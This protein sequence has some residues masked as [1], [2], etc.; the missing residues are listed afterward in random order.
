MAELEDKDAELEALR[1]EITKLKLELADS[2][3]KSLPLET[4][5]SEHSTAE[6]TTSTTTR[7][8]ASSD[9]SVDVR[10]GF[11]FGDKTPPQ[12]VKMRNVSLT[13]ESR[14][15]EQ[16]TPRSLVTGTYVFQ[17]PIRNAQYKRSAF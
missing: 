1:A 12:V 17:S 8:H 6:P 3:L 10:S 9:D 4:L 15:E 5:H 2:R 16:S 13:K 14:K 7:E 11:Y